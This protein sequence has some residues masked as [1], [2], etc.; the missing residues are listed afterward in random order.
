MATNYMTGSLGLAAQFKQSNMDARKQQRSTE[1]RS[2]KSSP[3]RSGPPFTPKRPSCPTLEHCWVQLGCAYH[4][5]KEPRC[6]THTKN[7]RPWFI[8]CNT[9]AVEH[10]NSCPLTKLPGRLFQS[11]SRPV[12]VLPH[13][14]GWMWLA[15]SQTSRSAWPTGVESLRPMVAA[16]S[17]GHAQLVHSCETAPAG[18]LFLRELSFWSV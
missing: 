14:R 15:Y 1:L 3:H 7:G 16:S 4:Y 6:H 11:P 12:S 18:S 10:T 8:A 9:P 17:P 13:L 2:T 5:S